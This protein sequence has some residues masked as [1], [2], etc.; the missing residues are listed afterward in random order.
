MGLDMYLLSLPKIHGMDFEEIKLASAQLSKHEADQNEIYEKLKPHIKNFRKLGISG[1]GLFEEVAYWRKANQIHNWFVENLH[2]GVD[3]P[4][5]TVEVTKVNLQELYN[6]CL[7]ILTR[8][9]RPKEALPTKPGCYFGSTA[10]D[11]Y[12]YREIGE[13]KMTVENLLKHFNFETHYLVY[14][15]SW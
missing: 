7:N 10:Y 13:T 8:R 15:C 1:F 11:S 2:N 6:L 12:F 9:S 14:Q 5:F 4:L 3:A